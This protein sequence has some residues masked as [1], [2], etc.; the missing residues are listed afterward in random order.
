MNKNKLFNILE[1]STFKLMGYL[2]SAI[3]SK[4]Y[5]I[6]TDD[7]NYIFAV[8][9]KASNHVMLVSH[10]DTVSRPKKVVL[11]ENNGVLRNLNGVLGAD[12]RAGVFAVLEI[13]EKSIKANQPL[14]NLLFTNYEETGGVGVRQFCKDK[15]AQ[16]VETDIWLMIELDRRGVNDAVYYSDPELAVK[17]LVDAVGYKEAWGSYSDVSTLSD[18]NDIA[19]VNLS[20]GYFNEHSKDEILVLSIVEYAI[21]NVLALMP[22]VERQYNIEYKPKGYTWTKGGWKDGYWSDYDWDKMYNR[23]T[24]TVSKGATTKKKEVRAIAEYNVETSR[25]PLV[26]VESDNEY[27]AAMPKSCP[28]CMDWEDVREFKA[29]GYN[30][31][32]NCG[33]YFDNDWN[34]IEWDQKDD[35]ALAMLEMM[36]E[37]GIMGD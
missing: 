36:E 5:T 3:R 18:H 30:Y 32:Q 15:I 6:Y 1:M 25:N 33:T 31:C 28:A 19:H 10:I 20:I 24:K 22:M 23:T 8:P 29:L 9:K 34:V 37:Y 26:L 2:H 14:P 35:E 27:Y 16:N 17:D 11:H 21:D 12:D 7:D 4:H 13:V